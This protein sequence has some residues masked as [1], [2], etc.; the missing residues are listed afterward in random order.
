M[1]FSGWLTYGTIFSAGG[2]RRP[3]PPSATDAPMSFMKSRRS[4]PS[5]ER[6]RAWRGNSSSQELVE[7]VARA[8]SSS[9][10]RQY[11]LS[12]RQIADALSRKVAVYVECLSSLISATLT[13]L[14]MTCRAG[15]Q[16]LNVVLLHQLRAELSWFFAT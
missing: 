11:S 7:D 5:L 10:L 2:C 1:R 16:L 6:Q 13:A 3:D 15:R 8:T 4:T 12:P 9:R 14:V